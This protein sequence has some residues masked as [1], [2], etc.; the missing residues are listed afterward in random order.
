MRPFTLILLLTLAAPPAYAWGNRGHQI[1]AL[2]AE[3]HLT[4]DARAEVNQLL[5]GDSLADVS[6]WADA[7]KN[8]RPETKPWHFADI[9]LAEDDYNAGRDCANDDCI[10]AAIARF[11]TVLADE[12]GDQRERA[13][14]L[15]FIVHF[16]G[17]M[18]QP[19]HCADNNDRGGN[20]VKVRLLGN[21]A[22][23]H[24][25][26]DSRL[27][28]RAGRAD[29]AAYVAHLETLAGED[30]LDALAEGT[31]EDWANEAHDVAET[32]V[33]RFSGS[34]TLGRSYVRRNVPVVDAQLL[35]A[36]LRL[37]AVVNEALD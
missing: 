16:V 4:A 28:D 25:V 21:D 20:D 34:R 33:Y 29:N 23:L 13:E 31:V 1:V 2:L 27:I 6:T 18:H 9:P 11:R 15:R 32:H 17:D 24:Q 3:R 10:V 36:G 37:A 35:R 8:E 26:W 5:G 7:V 19:L 12:N 22:N 14:A 30:E